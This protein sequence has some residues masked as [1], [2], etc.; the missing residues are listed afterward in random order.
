[1]IYTI[2]FNPSL[3]YVVRLTEFEPGNLHRS[4][5]EELFVGGK[6]INVSIVLKELGVESIALGFVAGFT[7]NEICHRLQ[8]MGISSDFV[9]LNQGISRINVKLKSGRAMETE[10]N[11]Q[12]PI[13]EDEELEQLYNK[14]EDMQVGD[15]LV[16]SGSVPMGVARADHI[17]EEFC[18]RAN[19]KKVK[20]VVDA[21]GN[22]LRNALQEK[23]FLIKPNK[24]ELEKFFGRIFLSDEDLLSCVGELQKQGATNVLLSLGERGALLLDEYGNLHRQDAPKGRI[25]NTVGCGDSMVAGFLAHLVKISQDYIVLT[26]EDYEE[27][28][29]WGVAAGS[30]GA[31]SDELPQKK[32]IETIY[33]SL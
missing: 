17:Y 18:R 11:G 13:P 9:S 26:A 30:A 19:A 7:G 1:M 2:T 3:D 21:E 8:E 14:L 16:I 23:P 22:L 6:G 10:I 4:E 28:L 29:K 5:E 24:H 20:L 25:I 32:E 31:F 12:G 15:I 27:A 33:R